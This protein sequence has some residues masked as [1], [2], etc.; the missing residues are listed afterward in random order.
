MGDCEIN[1]R[2]HSPNVIC[3]QFLHEYTFDLLLFTDTR[4]LHTYSLS[5]SQLFNFPKDPFTA[6]IQQK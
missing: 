5:L 4:S 6:V 3:L 2:N 1:G